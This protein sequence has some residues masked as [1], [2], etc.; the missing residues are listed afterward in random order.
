M[1]AYFIAGTDMGVGKTLTAT[2]LISRLVAAGQRVAAMKPVSAG[3]IRSSE[4]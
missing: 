1:S 4:G 2:A 3:C